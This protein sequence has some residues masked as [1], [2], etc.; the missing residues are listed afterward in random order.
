MCAFN[1]QLFLFHPKLLGIL[2]DLTRGVRSLIVS[3]CSTKRLRLADSAAPHCINTA[4]L[5]HFR[6]ERLLT[7]AFWLTLQDSNLQPIV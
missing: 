1:R 6:F 5:T 4:G 2:F 3:T 7:F